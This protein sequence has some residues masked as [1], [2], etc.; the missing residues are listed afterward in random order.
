MPMTIKNTN[1]FDWKALQNLRIFGFF[2][3]KISHLATPPRAS[4]LLL[5]SSCLI[6]LNTPTFQMQKTK[7]SSRLFCLK[8]EPQLPEGTGDFVRTPEK[9]VRQKFSRGTQFLS[10]PLFRKPPSG[11]MLNNLFSKM[12]V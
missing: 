2:V 5:S 7:S 1:V 12:A 6:E 10:S 9:F 3:L 11:V 4:A 8:S